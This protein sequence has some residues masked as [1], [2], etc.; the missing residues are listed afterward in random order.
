MENPVYPSAA[1]CN[2]SQKYL[3]F[4]AAVSDQRSAFSFCM[5]AVSMRFSS[6]ARGASS[7]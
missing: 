6:V 7:S 4:L 1:T 2:S 5:S 3:K